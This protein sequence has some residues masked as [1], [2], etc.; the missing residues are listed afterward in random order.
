MAA[1]PGNGIALEANAGA[2]VICTCANTV[3]WCNACI[4]KLRAQADPA[5]TIILNRIRPEP[6]RFIDPAELQHVIDAG[7]LVRAVLCGS[8]RRDRGD[9]HAEWIALNAE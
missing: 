5:A 1:R 7:S 2:L 4:A 3:W 8:D 9:S 6:P